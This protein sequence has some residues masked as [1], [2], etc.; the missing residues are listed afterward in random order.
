MKSARQIAFISVGIAMILLC[1]VLIFAKKSMGVLGEGESGSKVFAMPI[2]SLVFEAGACEIEILEGEGTEI[3]LD[4]EGLKYGTLVT[5]Q[6]EEELRISF[7]QDTSWIARLFAQEEEQRITLTV[8]KDTEF[9]SVR[10]EFG[11]AEINIEG[12]TAKELAL[13]VGAGELEADRLTAT[14][15]AKLTVGAGSMSAKNV[16]LTNARLECGV[17]EM[18]MSGSFEGDT[19]ADCGIGAM[20]LVVCG[21][22]EQYRGEINCGLGKVNLGNIKV[23]DGTKKFGSSSA[24]CRMDI[25]CGIGEV[26]VRFNN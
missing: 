14:E 15:S 3:L 2:R 13:T 1:V 19:N 23:K 5:K 11:A 24:D 26:D 7:K 22:Q 16:N 18:N 25:K 10:F 20:E 9:D 21:E 12:I 6:E 17:G 4:F 8:P